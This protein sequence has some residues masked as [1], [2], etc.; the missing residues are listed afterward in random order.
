MAVWQRLTPEL[1][2][3]R[4]AFDRTRL[5]ALF[6]MSGWMTI[7][8]VGTLLFLNIDLIVVNLALG[9]E[10]AGRYGSVLQWPLLLRTFAAAISGALTPLILMEYAR[11]AEERI[12]CLSRQA[13][14]LLGLGMALPVG[15]VCGLARPLLRLWLGSD[16]A[17]LAPLLVVM[18]AHL[19][20]NLAVLPLFSIQ[21]ALNRVKW[22]GIVT[23]LMGFAN[24]GLAVWWSGWEANGLGV[25]LAGGLVLLLK[26][27]LF[28][29][30]Y[31]AHIQRLRYTAFLSSMAPGV[32]GATA[33]GLVCYALGRVCAIGSWPA[34]IG[35]AC[36]VAAVY[37][38]VAYTV[39]L[40]DGERRLLAALAPWRASRIRVH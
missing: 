22:P 24:L 17:S 7:N 14:K 39:G 32:V 28:T 13:V 37:A 40:D 3:D 5:A 8:Q 31:S 2:V 25:A 11:G 9:A 23:L 34:F 12:T 29:P 38:A 6:Q 19:C 15:V 36:L 1:T 27:A 20:I 33:V 16:F 4:R 26:N 10:A 35:L 21:V 18:I 30:L